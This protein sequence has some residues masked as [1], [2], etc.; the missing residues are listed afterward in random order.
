MSEVSVKNPELERLP[1]D[2]EKP[3]EGALRPLCLDEFIGQKDLRE[4]LKIFIDAARKRCDNHFQSK[5]KARHFRGRNLN[6]RELRVAFFS[7]K[8]N[9]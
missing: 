3:L 5:H 6:N 9:I 1:Q 8:R 7:S 2:Q 4:N